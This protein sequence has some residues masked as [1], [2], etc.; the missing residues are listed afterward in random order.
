[1]AAQFEIVERRAQFQ[2][3]ETL[4]PGKVARPNEFL[5]ALIRIGCRVGAEAHNFGIVNLLTNSGGDLERGIQPGARALGVTG[6]QKQ[7]CD[8]PVE[9]RSIHLQPNT[10]PHVEQFG[11][12]CDPSQ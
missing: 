2:Q 11:K 12:P 5:L 8:H 3:R 9:E 6:K 10:P 7:A 1:L 4:A